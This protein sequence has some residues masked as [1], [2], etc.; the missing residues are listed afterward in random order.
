MLLY[1]QISQPETV[2]FRARTALRQLRVALLHNQWIGLDSVVDVA[3]AQPRRQE[4]PAALPPTQPAQKTSSQS[5]KST[6]QSQKSTQH[7]QQS[8]QHSSKSTQQSQKSTQHSSKSTQ[9]SQKAIS[10]HPA[11]I[12]LPADRTSQT[13]PS[14]STPASAAQGST[15]GDDSQDLLAFISWEDPTPA[16]LQPQASERKRPPTAAPRATKRPEAVQM[17]SFLNSLFS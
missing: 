17:E 1:R 2:T 9:H 13:T 3:L 16:P 15:L 7:S 11:P 5:Q 6:Q 10:E 12:P 4:E 14:L 8:T